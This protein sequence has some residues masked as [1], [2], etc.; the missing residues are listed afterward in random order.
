MLRF[1]RSAT[2]HSITHDQIRYVIDHR[3]L[4]FTVPAPPGAWGGDRMLLLGDDAH[5]VPLEVVALEVGETG[6]LSPP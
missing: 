6:R 3:G 1:A 5:G 2:K 4:P